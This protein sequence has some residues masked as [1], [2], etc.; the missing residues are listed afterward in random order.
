MEQ[1]QELFIVFADLSKA[2]DTVDR[3]LLW[4][5][6]RLFG[7]PERLVEMIR[8]LHDGMKA[9]VFV[10]DEQSNTQRCHLWSLLLGPQDT[11]RR[12]G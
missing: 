3:D 5:V 4:K 7:C 10:G 1:Q 8:L 9:T 2:F 11:T 6:L 12:V